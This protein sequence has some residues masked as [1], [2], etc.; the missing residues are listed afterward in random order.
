MGSRCSIKPMH[1]SF[2][3]AYLESSDFVAHVSLHAIRP[4]GA[5]SDS[6]T[7]LDVCLVFTPGALPPRPLLT[8]SYSWEGGS[9]SPE[10]VSSSSVQIQGGIAAPKHIDSGTT[11]KGIININKFPPDSIWGVFIGCRGGDSQMLQYPMY[12]HWF[13]FLNV[14]MRIPTS[15]VNMGDMFF[16]L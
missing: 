5:H 6:H 11:D 4:K 13:H 7:S 9:N 10:P 1:D 2:A 8:G 15:Y 14:S 12:G 16:L 3:Y